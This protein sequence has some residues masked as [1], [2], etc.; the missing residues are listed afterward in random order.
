MRE[1]LVWEVGVGG[2]GFSS[3]LMSS[4]GDVVA[5]V[6]GIVILPGYVLIKEFGDTLLQGKS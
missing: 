2:S 5:I 1:R 3:G 4:G 6:C